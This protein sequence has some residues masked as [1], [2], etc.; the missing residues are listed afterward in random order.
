MQIW[1]SEAPVGREGSGSLGEDPI[2]PVRL[3]R[4]YLVDAFAPFGPR[5]AA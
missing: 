1:R 5:P 2:E 4:Y 3:N